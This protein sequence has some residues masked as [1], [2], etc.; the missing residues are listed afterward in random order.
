VAGELLAPAVDE[1]CDGDGL[2]GRGV[3]LDARQPAADD[4][5]RTGRIRAGVAVGVGRAVLGRH[6]ADIGVAGVEDVDVG[7]GRPTG[8]DGQ[9][10]HAAVPVVVRV[11]A[12]ID[13]GGRRRVRE[14]VEGP[15]HAALLGHEDG[16]AARR[17]AH[18][19]RLAQAGEGRRGLEAGRERRRLIGGHEDRQTG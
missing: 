7:P 19:G 2:V 12:Q 8:I 16:A 11:G 18:G 3:D 13:H 6:P 9:P 15:D 5:A 17:E 14:A 4:A 1:G 10:E